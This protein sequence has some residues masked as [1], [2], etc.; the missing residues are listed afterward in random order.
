MRTVIVES[1]RMRCEFIRE[2]C[3]Q[4]LGHDLVT[5]TDDGRKAAG[6][7]RDLAPELVVTGLRLRSLGGLHLLDEVSQ[8]AP[9]SR[10]VLFAETPGAYVVF[11][12][13]K[14]KVKGFVDTRA[15]GRDAARAAITGVCENRVWY[16]PVVAEVTTAMLVGSCSFHRVLSPQDMDILEMIGDSLSNPEIS[17]I[18][19][20]AVRTVQWHHEKIARKV[21]VS[22]RADLGTFAREHGFSRFVI[23]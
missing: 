4:E 23:A 8:E 7:I 19:G 3:E 9:A 6:L 10:I 2:I 17:H 21:G 15:E 16:S 11:R 20:I 5:C 13:G 22:G 1:D 12:I 18:L 14:A